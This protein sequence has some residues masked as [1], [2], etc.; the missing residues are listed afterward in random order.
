MASLDAKCKN[1]LKNRGKTST[2][3]QL[4][5]FQGLTSNPVDGMPFFAAADWQHQDDLIRRDL[6]LRI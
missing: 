6:G 4:C 1:L 5:V 2:G 3:A